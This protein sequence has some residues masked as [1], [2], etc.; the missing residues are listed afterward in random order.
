MLKIFYTDGACSGNPGPGGFGVVEFDYGDGKCLCDYFEGAQKPSYFYAHKEDHTTNNRMELEAILHAFRIADAALIEAEEKKYD[1]DI[2]IYSDSAY[3][4]NMLNSWIFSW[5]ANGWRRS[6]N[7][8][9]ENLDLVKTLYNYINK[10]SFKSQVRVVKCPGHRGVL[11]NE[12]ADALATG[13][14]NRYNKLLEKIS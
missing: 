8:P 6:K 10:N 2:I 3:A 1:V 7:Q 14:M 9:I 12:L 11:G 13:D 5:E 4:V